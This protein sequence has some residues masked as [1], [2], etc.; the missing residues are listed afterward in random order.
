MPK[1]RLT[2][3]A[4]IDLD[5]I[6]AFVAVDNIDAAVELDARFTDIFE[7]LGE[8]PRL[9]RERPELDYGLRSFPAGSY[10][11]FYRTS[12]GEVLIVRVIHSARDLE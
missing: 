10:L 2:S 7:M 6:A 4:D 1:Y 5:D 8:N 3:Q 11:V 12:V 9:G